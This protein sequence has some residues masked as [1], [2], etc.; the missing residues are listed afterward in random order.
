MLKNGIPF[1]FSNL[2][3]LSEF[4]CSIFGATL[5]PVL[6]T[7]AFLDFVQMEVK[8]HMEFDPERGVRVLPEPYPGGNTPLLFTFSRLPSE[9]GYD[10]DNYISH[11]KTT[12]TGTYFSLAELV[13]TFFC[14]PTITIDQI[15]PDNFVKY[16]LPSYKQ[17]FKCVLFVEED[18]KVKTRPS[19]DEGELGVSNDDLAMTD[20]DTMNVSPVKVEKKYGTEDGLEEAAKQLSTKILTYVQQGKFGT[21]TDELETS[22]AGVRLQKVGCLLTTLGHLC[23]FQHAKLTAERVDSED[24]IA[25]IKNFGSLMKKTLR[26]N[27][28]KAGDEKASSRERAN[29]QRVSVSSYGILDV[30]TATFHLKYQ[31]LLEVIMEDSSINMDQF[32][33]KKDQDVD[34]DYTGKWDLDSFDKLMT[35][36]N[37]GKSNNTLRLPTKNRNLYALLAEVLL[38]QGDPLLHNAQLNSTL[39][40]SSLAPASHLT[41][42][43]A[44]PPLAEVSPAHPPPSHL[45]TGPS[46][47]HPSVG[48]PPVYPPAP[49]VGPP[50]YPPAL[51]QTQF[52]SITGYPPTLPPALSWGGITAYHPSFANLDPPPSPPARAILETDYSL[53]T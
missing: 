29:N 37:G 18:S 8:I 9:D 27:P 22:S 36:S 35:D 20:A 12:G 14:K 17:R 21:K 50:V 46:Y 49:A 34:D 24:P 52:S 13:A 33:P 39:N 6:V 4:V 2:E 11:V 15:T 25:F 38:P 32:G 51:E 31:K 30:G 48:P 28:L 41:T 53:C 42:G 23:A 10:E 45:M 19:V 40:I 1:A 5:F 44:Y 16:Y 47:V 43:P 26:L 7:E 3:V